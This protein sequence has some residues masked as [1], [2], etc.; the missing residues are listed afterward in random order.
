MKKIFTNK[1]CVAL[2]AMLCCALWG[3]AFPIIKIGYNLLSI[4][5]LDSASQILFAGVRF[6]FAGVLTILLGS[7]FADKLIVIKQK[8]NFK[9]VAILALF[10]TVLQYIFFYVGLAHTTG[11]KARYSIPQ[12]YFLPCS[13][14]ALFL[15]RK[16]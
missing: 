16:N 13:F 15:S 4:A 3:S 1:I 6:L 10:Q 7:L 8:S 12:A 2:I 9:M 11:T 5:S 14:R